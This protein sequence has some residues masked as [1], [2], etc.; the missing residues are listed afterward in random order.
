[1]KKIILAALMAAAI[2]SCKDSGAKALILYYSQTGTTDSLATELRRQTGADICRF[3]VEQAYSGTYE[4]TIARCLEE[5]EAEFVP[6]LKPLD[7]DL[8]GYDVIFLGYPIWFGTFAPPVKA[9]LLSGKLAGKTVV[10]FCTFGSGGIRSSTEDLRRELPYSDVREGYGVRSARIGAAAEELNR[11]LVE[12]G[13]KEGSVEP[14]PEFS[15]QIPVSEEKTAIFEAACSGYKYPI[16]T[17]VT[18]GER[19][20]PGGIEYKFAVEGFTPDGR[21]SAVTVFVNVIGEK[22]PEF[23][24]VIR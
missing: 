5:R 24:Q 1:M 9:L 13:W 14:L 4:Q 20:I 19:K 18:V 3:D 15:E 16:G 17:P 12:N 23:T 2:T 8:S 6:D 21:L 7:V 11:F 22:E 10:P